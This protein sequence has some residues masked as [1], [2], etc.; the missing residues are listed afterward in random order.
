MVRFGIKNLGLLQ[1]SGKTIKITGQNPI[2][3]IRTTARGSLMV[4]VM[5][6]EVAQRMMRM[7]LSGLMM[8]IV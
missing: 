4:R 5:A 7:I 1:T 8:I 6:K 3:I 2:M